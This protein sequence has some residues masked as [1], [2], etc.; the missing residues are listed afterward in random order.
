MDGIIM[1]W[2]KRAQQKEMN[3]YEVRRDGKLLFVGPEAEC[4]HFIHKH[5]SY[6]VDWAMKYEGWTITPKFPENENDAAPDWR[7]DYQWYG[8]EE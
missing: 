6:S 4:W 5:T 1:K 3:V 8:G 7:D 2:F